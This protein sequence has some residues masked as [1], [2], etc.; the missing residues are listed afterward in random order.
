M[1]DSPTRDRRAEVL[2]AAAALVAAFGAHD[3]DGYFAAFAPEATF[4][5]HSTGRLLRSRAEYRDLW[6]Q[7][8][9]DG[10]A[11][12]GCTSTLGRV[13]LI[14]EDVAVFT[15]R[16]HTRLQLDGHP[17]VLDERETIVFRRVDGR[18]LGVHEHLSPDPATDRGL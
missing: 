1:S 7:W 15:H 6:D 16:V 10:F 11:V 14:T 13:D 9:A 3:T 17:S 18:W 2:A 5:F 12:V 8:E 4:L